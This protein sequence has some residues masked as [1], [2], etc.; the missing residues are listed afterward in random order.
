M[1]QLF[2][3]QVH[4]RSHT[5]SVTL[6][7]RFNAAQEVEEIAAEFD[8]VSTCN[9]QAWLKKS[10]LERDGAKCVVTGY[11]DDAEAERLP[12]NESASLVTAT[13]QAAHI[14]PFSLGSSVVSL[15]SS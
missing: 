15:T 12:A 4:A 13:T 6:S 2:S 10:C 14:L 11:Y 5:P 8:G 3:L 7:P 9:S 1:T